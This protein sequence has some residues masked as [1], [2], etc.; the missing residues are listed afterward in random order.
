MQCRLRLSVYR[1][2][3]KFCRRHPFGASSTLIQFISPPDSY[4]NGP[5]TKPSSDMC[6][7]EI[8]FYFS[9]KGAKIKSKTPRKSFA[10]LLLGVF[11]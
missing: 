11:E 4:R 5:A 2:D 3:Q 8:I 10:A 1:H 9:R 7:N 6:I